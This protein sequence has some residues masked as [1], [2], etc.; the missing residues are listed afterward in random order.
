[1]HS[2]GVIHRDIKSLNIMMNSNGMLKIGDLGVSRQV[3]QD[4]MMLQ[5]FYG[6][7]LYASPELCENKPYCEKTDIWSLGVVLYEIACLQPPF[8]GPNLIA[9]ANAIKDA[10]YPPITTEPG[11]S[12]SLVR[13]VAMLLQ[14]KQE[15]RPSIKQILSWFKEPPVQYLGAA[16]P[17][18]KML[19]A[20]ERRMQQMREDRKQKKTEY[21]MLQKKLREQQAM[22]T[23][24]DAK[25][26]STSPVSSPTKPTARPRD[27]SGTDDDFDEYNKVMQV[28]LAS[29]RKKEIEEEANLREQRR[30]KG[31]ERAMSEARAMR[32]EGMPS[33][34]RPCRAP[35]AHA[36]PRSWLTPLRRTSWRSTGS[37]PAALGPYQNLT[38]ATTPLCPI[39]SS[40]RGICKRKGSGW[41]RSFGG[42]SC[43][44]AT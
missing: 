21:E 32:D 20:E 9:L 24:V 22:R 42:N 14:R 27:M 39:R 23:K 7:P 34:A 29:R 1:M 35:L 33:L 13:M 3:G 17:N 30:A 38:T 41:P 37:R 4:T 10:R 15:K 6:T 28:R 19:S 31:A 25:V 12:E 18:K 36:A 11:Y 5:T 43:S 44:C 8:S 16:D 26:V 2:N 40:T